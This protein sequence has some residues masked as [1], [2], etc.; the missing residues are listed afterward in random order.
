MKLYQITYDL[1]N[2]R[3]YEELYERLQ[4][5]RQSCRPLESTWIIRSDQRAEAICEHLRQVLDDDDGMLVT[6]LTG[7]AGGT[8]LRSREETLYFRKMLSSNG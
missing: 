6:E 4:A 3:N 8:N 5:F 7:V 2:H 1:R